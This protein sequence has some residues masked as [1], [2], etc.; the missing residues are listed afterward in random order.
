MW[1]RYFGEYPDSSNIC[2]HNIDVKSDNFL[3]GRERHGVEVFT[4]RIMDDFY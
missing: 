3:L 4:Y 1:V 2:D